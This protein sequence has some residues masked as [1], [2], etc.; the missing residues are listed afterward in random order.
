[1]TTNNPFDGANYGIKTNDNRG[2]YQQCIEYCSVRLANSFPL[3]FGW[4]VFI[5][6][7]YHWHSHWLNVDHARLIM[8]FPTV[9]D[10]CPLIISSP[11]FLSY[12]GAQVD[13]ED[14]NQPAA[15]NKMD[16]PTH[17]YFL[18]LRYL[19]I[20]PDR[21]QERDQAYACPQ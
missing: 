10:L 13:E 12:L 6:T 14:E 5:I 4:T 17:H 21:S 1:M 19:V 15:A 16:C 8:S 3:N 9:V 7:L 18:K 20:L 2:Y 11:R